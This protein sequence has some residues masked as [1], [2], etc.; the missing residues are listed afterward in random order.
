MKTI[1]RNFLSVL[2]RYKLATALNVLGLSVAFAAFMVIMM[3]V[4]YDRGFDRFHRDADR[5][6]QVEFN[7]REGGYQTVINRPFAEELIRSSPHILAGAVLESYDGNL[8]FST[9]ANGDRNYYRENAI[10]VTPSFADVFA[11]DMVE[12]TD[13]ALGDPDKALIPLSLS[14]KLFGGEPATGRQLAGRNQTLT[15]GGVYR[16]FPRNTSV[17]N[18]IYMPIPPGE[19][20]NDWHSWNYITYIR[21]DAAENVERLYAD[22]LEKFDF[23]VMGDEKFTANDM[24][25]RF[26]ALPEIHFTTDVA[27]DSTPKSSRQTMLILLAIAFVIV[28]IAGINYT[29]FS[30]ALAPKRIRSINTQRVLGGSVGVIRTA[31]VIEGVAVSLLSF[32]L[33][34]GLVRL[35]RDTPLTSLVEV[36]V[37]LLLHTGLIAATAGLAVATGLLAGLYPSYYVTSFPP[38]MALK[39]SFGLS[40]RGR[41][42]RSALISV[43]FVASF[44]LIIGASF[45]YLQHYY[46]HHTPLGYDKDELIVTDL[47]GKAAG[48]REAID[49]RL[50]SL[51]GIA[52]VVY[53]ETLLSSRDQYMGWGRDYRDRRISFQCLPVDP[54]FLRVMGIAIAEGRDFREEDAHTRHGTFIFNDKARAMY[55][56]DLNERI[57]SAEI[58]G[59]MPD[60]KFASFRREVEPMAFHVWG[61]RNRDAL[62]NFAY[63]KVNAG[64]DL[65]AAMTHVRSTLAAFDGEYPFDVRFYDEVLNRTYEQE[66]RLSSLITLFS[67]IAILISIVGVFGLVVFDSEYRRKEIGIR[68]VFG[69]TTGEILV[70]F[71]KGYVRIL[72]LCFVL[73]APVAWYAVDRWLENFAYKTPMYWWV[74]VAAFAVVFI[75]TVATVTFQNWRAANMNPVDSLKA[76]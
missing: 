69:S 42:L 67:M 58:V 71:N 5:I 13:R 64:V 57:D 55:G 48:N 56:L 72:A 39:G 1:I 52:D 33:G 76:N 68:R 66:Q 37:S 20:L 7:L 59:F 47:S 63:V 32:L 35:M 49:G 8:F 23:A 61:T 70:M 53:S 62:P 16:D 22:F 9:E 28:V 27:Y 60:V 26:T 34:L 17:K 29:N 40:P 31:L 24:T 15:V 41:Q 10:S 50:K 43:Q 44:I 6:F 54:S 18:A 51:A 36:D 4:D 11:F 45:M 3:Q 73:A 38:A 21:M 30:A 74:Y 12:G 46:M 14:L 19:G 25:C 2:R 65:R 75:L